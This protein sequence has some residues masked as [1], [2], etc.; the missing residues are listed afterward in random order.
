MIP[1]Q[2]GRHD[3]CHSHASQRNCI[4]EPCSQ[5]LHPES[6]IEIRFDPVPL[7][8]GELAVT[9]GAAH[10]RRFSRDL[11]VL[12]C[13]RKFSTLDCQDRESLPT[14][15]SKSKRQG[16]TKNLQVHCC[17]GR[18]LPCCHYELKATWCLFATCSPGL[19]GQ[20]CKHP[21][22]PR[23]RLTGSPMVLTCVLL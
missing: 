8:F 20:S 4:S 17:P 9:Q 19:S 21:T 18:S 13:F 5:S 6:R 2:G 15:C 11:Q 7:T 3:Q 14:H 22:P 10:H 23:Q 12:W 1:R 16:R